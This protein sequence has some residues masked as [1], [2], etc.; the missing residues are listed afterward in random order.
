MK[1]KVRAIDSKERALQRQLRWNYL[2]S[3]FWW[4]VIVAMFAAVYALTMIVS[5]IWK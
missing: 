4:G 3:A 1:S 5:G 2:R